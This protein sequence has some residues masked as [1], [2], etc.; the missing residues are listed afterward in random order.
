[1]SNVGEFWTISK[2][3]KIAVLSKNK[4][5]DSLSLEAQKNIRVIYLDIH[6]QYHASYNV[7]T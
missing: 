1:M 2:R 4:Q 7:D 5:I 6:I 3:K